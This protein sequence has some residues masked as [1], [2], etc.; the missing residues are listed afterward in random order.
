LAAPAAVVAAPALG[1]PA[2]V[3]GAP[4]LDGLPLA[5]LPVAGSLAPAQPA[6]PNQAA[7]ASVS[8][9]TCAIRAIERIS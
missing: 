5:P 6:M 1:A 8:N 2:A 4:A 7:V 9:E 3:L